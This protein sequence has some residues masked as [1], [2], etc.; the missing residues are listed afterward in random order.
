MLGSIYVL[1]L[2]APSRVQGVLGRG[3]GCG[4]AGSNP[5]SLLDLRQE[6][7]KVGPGTRV[8]TPRGFGGLHICEWMWE[9]QGRGDAC[10]C[11][12]VGLRMALKNP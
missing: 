1:K 8:I 2:V 4:Q 7:L 9:G 11:G 6:V 3:A 5:A 12:L 10:D